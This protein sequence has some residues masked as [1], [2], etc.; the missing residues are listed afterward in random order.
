MIQKY[1]VKLFTLD[2]EQKWLA[3]FDGD[4]RVSIKDATKIQYKLAGML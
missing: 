1:L 2:D 3:D 4:G